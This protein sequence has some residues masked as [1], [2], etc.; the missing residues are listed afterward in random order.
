MAYSHPAFAIEDFYIACRVVRMVHFVN[1]LVTRYN[2]WIGYA[3][4]TQDGFSYTNFVANY[5]ALEIFVTRI[6][7]RGF[8]TKLGSD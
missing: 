4:T 7:N 2:C 3:E 6:F 8:S 1:C 5:E